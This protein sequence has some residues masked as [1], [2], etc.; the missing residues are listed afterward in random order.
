METE[1][2][3]ALADAAHEARMAAGDLADDE[4]RGGDPTLLDELEKPVAHRHEPRLLA[5][6][7]AA[8]LEI[9]GDGHGHALTRPKS[10]VAALSEYLVD[11]ELPHC[12]VPVHE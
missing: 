5:G 8:I 7:A 6:G 4:H 3:A 12:K 1:L 9:E 2:V 11:A 10:S